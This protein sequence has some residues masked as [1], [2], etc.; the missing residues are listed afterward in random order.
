MLSRLME[1]F[2]AAINY[3]LYILIDGVSELKF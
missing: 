2:V 3:H 1:L